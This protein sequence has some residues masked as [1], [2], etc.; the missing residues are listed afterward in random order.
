MHTSVLI[1]KVAY[2]P[3]LFAQVVESAAVAFLSIYIEAA[4][5]PCGNGSRLFVGWHPEVRPWANPLHHLPDR[6]QEG[7]SQA[8][9][10][11]SPLPR[12]D[13]EE[14]GPGC[15][16]SSPPAFLSVKRSWGRSKNELE[17]PGKGLLGWS[18]TQWKSS[19]SARS[20]SNSN[21]LWILSYWLKL[22]FGFYQPPARP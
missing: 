21:W 2:N 9:A 20:H 11:P 4:D 19:P 1:H 6:S 22:G 17:E 13:C 5:S 15:S 8:A 16:W 12:G 18:L 14:S 7:E 10:S 3:R